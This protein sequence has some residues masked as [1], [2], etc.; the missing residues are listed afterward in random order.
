MKLKIQT[1]AILVIWNVTL[2]GRAKNDKCF[3]SWGR[4][5]VLYALFE[6]VVELEKAVPVKVVSELLLFFSSISVSNEEEGEDLGWLE[7]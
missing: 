5:M 1:F 6:A 4:F 2:P 7:G 3:H